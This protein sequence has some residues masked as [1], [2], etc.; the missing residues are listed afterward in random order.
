M[1]HYTV[2]LLSNPEEGVYSVR[3][4]ELPGINT[5]GQTIEDALANAREAIE[6]HLEGLALDGEPIPQESEPVIVARISVSP[7]L[8][9][10][11]VT[12]SLA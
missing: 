6:V 10:N 8:S 4:P 11:P 5:W 12:T 9:V 2:V 7:E 1:L 3:V